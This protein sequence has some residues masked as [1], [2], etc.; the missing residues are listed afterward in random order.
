MRARPLRGNSTVL[1]KFSQPILD[2]S[3][4]RKTGKNLN[5][6]LPLGGLS[7]FTPVARMTTERAVCEKSGFVGLRLLLDFCL[8]F[9]AM[10]RPCH[11]QP[12]KENKIQTD[13]LPGR[14]P[15]SRRSGRRMAASASARPI[16]RATRLASACG[17][18]RMALVKH[19]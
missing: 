18:K 2:Y 11:T 16:S 17:E 10:P 4:T 8:G 9:L 14:R 3:I 12:R 1:P 5:N 7:D 19:S 6:H 13:P 15:G